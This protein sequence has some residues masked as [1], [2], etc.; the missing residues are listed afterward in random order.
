MAY[1]RKTVDCWDIQGCYNG[2]WE[3]VCSA[4]SWKEAKADIKDH[5]ENERGVSFRIKK[6]REKIV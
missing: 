1:K 2:V 6:Y 4:S 3:T 5:R